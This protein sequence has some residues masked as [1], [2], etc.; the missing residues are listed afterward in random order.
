MD[1]QALTCPQC[2]SANVQRTADGTFRCQNCGTRLLLIDKLGRL[3]IPQVEGWLDCPKCGTVNEAENFFCTHC[4]TEIRYKCPNCGT[5][6]LA[7]EPVCGVCGQTYQGAQVLVERNTLRRQRRR[8]S[9]LAG[10]LAAA[11]ML[12]MWMLIIT[13]LDWKNNN[14]IDTVATTICCLSPFV[15]LATS[16]AVYVGQRVLGN[17][18]T[19]GR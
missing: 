19:A 5:I 18:P 11:V 17:D 1:L 10:C 4:G 9:V 7:T 14:T 12:S 2:N 16:A 6:R 3:V 8:R 15:G 13:T